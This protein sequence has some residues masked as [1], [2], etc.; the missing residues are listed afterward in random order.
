V[1][2]FLAVPGVEALAYLPRRFLAESTSPVRIEQQRRYRITKTQGIALGH[3]HA[4]PSVIDDF[5]D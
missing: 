3:Q 2:Y 4:V 1:K 5:R